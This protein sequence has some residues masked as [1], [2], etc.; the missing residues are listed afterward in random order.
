MRTA[1]RLLAA[2]LFI[3]TV[4]W[5]VQS[6]RNPGWTKNQVAVEVKDEVT[7]IVGTIYEDRFVPGVDILAAAGAAAL[8]LGGLSFLGR[9]K[10][11]ATP[12]R[13]SGTAL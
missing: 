2:A 10:P 13:P 1:L 6:G 7:E 11:V 4:V 12:E 5:W 9:R 3:G 8:V